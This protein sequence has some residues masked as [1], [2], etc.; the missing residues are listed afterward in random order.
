[1]EEAEILLKRGWFDFVEDIYPIF[2]EL[3]DDDFW[4]LYR[5]RA[6]YDHLVQMAFSN[7]V[8][9]P[10]VQGK[11]SLNIIEEEEDDTEVDISGPWAH[12]FKLIQDQ[13][14]EF[15]KEELI[16]DLDSEISSVQNILD[17][18]R[19]NRTRNDKQ[20]VNEYVSSLKDLKIQKNKLVLEKKAQYDRW[21]EKEFT[22]FKTN[23]A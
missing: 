11:I 10:K 15:E 5:K 1:M 13:A 8:I 14:P 18:Y 12:H 4:T 21:V 3:S 6:G 9:F 17:N 22:R 20:I 2:R 23:F 7:C 19:V 16:Q